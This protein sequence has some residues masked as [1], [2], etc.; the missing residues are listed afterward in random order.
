MFPD[1]SRDVIVTTLQR[2]YVGI[3]ICAPST[4]FRIA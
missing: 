4:E 2:R 1:V 3:Y